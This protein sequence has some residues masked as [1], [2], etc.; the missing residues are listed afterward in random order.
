MS[1]EGVVMSRRT[2]TLPKGRMDHG[3]IS[4][5]IRTIGVGGCCC[6]SREANKFEKVVEKLYFNVTEA[7][8]KDRGGKWALRRGRAGCH[9]H[10]NE[11]SA[12]CFLKR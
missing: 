7:I 5:S 12:L 8:S 4:V 11:C 2:D 3:T 10:S 1:G 9:L 6:Q